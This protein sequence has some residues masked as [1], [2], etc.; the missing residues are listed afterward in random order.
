[1]GLAWLVGIVAAVAVLLWRLRLPRSLWTWGGTALALAVIGYALQGAPS[2]PGAVAAAPQRPTL[3]ISRD[4]VELRGAMFGRFTQ[5]AAYQTAADAMI[6]IN[7]PAAAVK[8]TLGGIN[9]APKSVALWTELGSTLATHDGNIVS[10]PALFAFRR[11]MQLAPRH[12][13]PPFFL[14]L[15]YIEAGQLAEG[16]YWWA[17]ALALTPQNIPLRSAIAEHLS[18]LDGFLKSAEEAEKRRAAAGQAVGQVAP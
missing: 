9:L 16:R 13:G 10:P 4:I 17:Q 18:L 14:G 7:L 2:L 6:R 12:P 3:E 1:M 11:A 8:V 15:S 5:D